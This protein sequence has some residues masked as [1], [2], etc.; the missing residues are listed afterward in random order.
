MID[1]FLEL[2]GLEDAFAVTLS[3]EQVER[4]K[5]APDVYLEC[6]NRLETD[7]ARCVAIED[8]ANG[9]RA[10]AAAGMPVIA[11]PNPHYPPEPEALAL[12]A[13]TIDGVAELTPELVEAVET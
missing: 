6:A 5:P 2:S 9:I 3:S 11:I 13:A 8:S 4:G 12:A 10:A 1:H 7:P